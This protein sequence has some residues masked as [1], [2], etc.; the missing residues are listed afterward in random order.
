M[1]TKG[2]MRQSLNLLKTVLSPLK[3]ISFSSHTTGNS[4]QSYSVLTL[5]ALR[6][7]LNIL[8]RCFGSLN[9]YGGLHS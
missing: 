4:G 3:S 6:T 2:I 5:I 1:C 9:E 7:F 8:Q